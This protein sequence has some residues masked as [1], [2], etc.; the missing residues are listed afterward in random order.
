M[1]PPPPN[2]FSRWD[3]PPFRGG[4]CACRWVAWACER[5]RRQGQR[6]CEEGVHTQWDLFIFL[7]MPRRRSTASILPSYWTGAAHLM[8]FISERRAVH[9]PR[10]QTPPPP[11]AARR[12]FIWSFG[13]D[14]S[15]FWRCSDLTPRRREENP[16]GRNGSWTQVFKQTFPHLCL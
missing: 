1:E 11:A 15:R 8:S 5:A 14:E 10:S 4:Q 12:R 6:P 13:R 2:A 7:I 3:R 9:R 16:E